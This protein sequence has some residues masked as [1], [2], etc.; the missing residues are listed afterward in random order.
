MIECHIT[1]NN[2]SRLFAMRTGFLMVQEAARS[3]HWHNTE[4]AF[5]LACH[6]TL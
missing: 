2:D 3:W 5:L 6:T 4:F 1:V